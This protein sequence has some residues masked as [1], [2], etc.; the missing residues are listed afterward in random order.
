MR[1][2]GYAIQGATSAADTDAARVAVEALGRL[3]AGPTVGDP[4]A[5]VDLVG[6]ERSRGR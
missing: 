5:E 2:L 4:S 1:A 6:E 3:L